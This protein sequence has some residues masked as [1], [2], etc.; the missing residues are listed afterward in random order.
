[1]KVAPT[2]FFAALTRSVDLASY[3]GLSLP[4]L[5]EIKRL[6][7]KLGVHTTIKAEEFSL[8]HEC[9]KCGKKPYEFLINKPRVDELYQH[10]AQN[11]IIEPPKPTPHFDNVQWIG[12][13]SHFV[14]ALCRPFAPI[15]LAPFAPPDQPI[16]A[17]RAAS[18]FDEI[19]EIRRASSLPSTLFILPFTPIYLNIIVRHPDLAHQAG[20][21]GHSPTHQ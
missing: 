17:F 4:S 2:K 3:V 8:I 7:F 15:N 13:F 6:A 16:E 18:V 10:L 9:L 14:E 20:Q 12:D 19:S 1:M 21:N 5:A 11:F